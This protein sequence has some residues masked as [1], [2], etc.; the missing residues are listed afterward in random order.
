[1]Q[2]TL[3]IDCDNAAFEDPRELPRILLAVVGA[4]ADR[5]NDGRLAAH[6][7]S[8][9]DVNGNRVGAWKIAP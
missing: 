6:T 4:V 9:H 7:R 2:F 5:E 3:T 8:V 1:M